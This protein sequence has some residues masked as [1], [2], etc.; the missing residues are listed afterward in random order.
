MEEAVEE[1]AEVDILPGEARREGVAEAC[2]RLVGWCKS[3]VRSGGTDVE[4]DVIVDGDVEAV[5]DDGEAA[6]ERGADISEQRMTPCLSAAISI[7]SA[8][9]RTE[10]RWSSAMLR[11]SA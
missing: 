7:S 6:G 8:E 9:R 3:R 2:E 1:A 10:S 11:C 5:V 4:P